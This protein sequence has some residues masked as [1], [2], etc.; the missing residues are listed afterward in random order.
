MNKIIIQTDD[1][2]QAIGA[3]SQGVRVG[4]LVFISGQIPLDA[5]SGEVVIGGAEDQIHRVFKNLLAVCQAAGGK[6]DDFVKLTIYL[7][8]LSLFSSV[9]TIMSEYFT[10]PYPA[11]AA[12]G[13]S[14]LPKGVS[15]E[16]EGILALPA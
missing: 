7:T 2:P 11:R 12:V 4:N 10:P 15:V 1:A 14:Q 5:A 9:N 13:V 3:Y 8:D 16:V 6:S